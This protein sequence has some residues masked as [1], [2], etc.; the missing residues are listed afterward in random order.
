[1]FATHKG[2]KLR[3]GAN[4][5]KAGIPAYSPQELGVALIVYIPFT[6]GYFTHSL[7]LFKYQIASIRATTTRPYDL[8]VFDNGSCSQVVEQLQS[9]HKQGEID[10]LILS[11]HNLGKAGAW[12]WIFSA[13]PNELIC[14]SDSDVLF[15]HGWLE[16]SL[17]I[18]GTFSQAGMVAAFPNFFDVMQGQSKANIKLQTD[19]SCDFDEYWPSKEIVDQ[20]C[21]SIGATDEQAAKFYK[22]PLPAVTKRESGIRAVIGASHMQFLTSRNVARQVV[23]L[24]ASK[25]LLRS[26]TMGFD[27]KI[28]ELGYLHLSTLE[29]Y[30]YHMGN[31]LNKRL[32][33]EVKSIIGDS[34]TM[35]FT[36][37]KAVSFDSTLQ[38]WLSA[39]VRRPRYKRLFLR[40]YNTLFRVLNVD[41]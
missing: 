3:T 39:L 12:N 11:Q 14:Y 34:S 10:W 8:L 26:E 31:T 2:F 21:I 22:K 5:A 7:E 33:D 16:A 41:N 15:R 35:K 23:P 20:Y 36:P 19:E 27:Y 18:L 6:E 38:R 28:D 9:L 17:K 30:V 13:M 37:K 40:I 29:P 4:P 25:G 32:I 1:M 24:P